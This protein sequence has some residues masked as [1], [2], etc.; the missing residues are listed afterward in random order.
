MVKLRMEI[1]KGE[2]IRY[3]SHLDFARAI[4]RSIRRSGL[5][6][7]YSEGFNPH[8]KMAFASAL[9]V[10]ITS[11]CEYMDIELKEEKNLAD[12]T[13]ALASQLAPG[14]KLKRA[15]YIHTASASLMSLVNMAE[16][17]IHVPFREGTHG[18]IVKENIE[19]FNQAEQVMFVRESS[20]GRREMDIKQYLPAGVRV[21]N[22]IGLAE[23]SFTSV[24]TPGGTVKPVE[25]LTVLADTFAVPVIKEEALIRRIGLYI[26]DNEGLRFSPLD[27]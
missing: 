23:I 24:I 2:E 4:E 1:T 10:G 26:A 13:E 12:I 5:P 6:A 25:V 9:G 18:A 16:Y 21:A 19:R 3:I 27:V 14:I 17:M 11:D 20:K 7:A 22:L 8:M 15:K